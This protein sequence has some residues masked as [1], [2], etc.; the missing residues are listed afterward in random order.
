MPRVKG[1]TNI[2]PWDVERLIR[3]M[4]V[5]DKSDP[6]LAAEYDVAEQTVRYF[7]VKPQFQD[8]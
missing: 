3:D 1:T 8:R 7:R 4:A 5:G 6:E 2:R